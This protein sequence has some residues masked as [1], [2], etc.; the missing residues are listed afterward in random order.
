[1][2]MMTVKDA[3]NLI[4][5]KSGPAISLYLVTDVS[6]RDGASKLRLNLQR[7]YK[8]AEGL[9]GRTYDGTTRERLLSSLKRALSMV[10]LKRAKGGVGIYHSEQF[11]GM[12]QLPNVTADLAVASDSFHIKPVL[13]CTQSRRNYYLL[14]LKRKYAE[15]LLVTADG[16]K[17]VDRIGINAG[18]VG[19][20]SAERGNRQWSSDGLKIRRQKDLKHAMELLNRKL[21]H[22]WRGERIPLVL[23][24]PPYSQEAFRGACS[25]MYMIERGVPVNV[26]ELDMDN[27]VSASLTAMAGYFD[28]LDDHAVVSFRRAHASGLVSTN[29]EAIA[30]A[31]AMG[32]IQSLLVAEDRH[33][34]GHLDRDT[35]HVKVLDSI[36]QAA[37]DDLLDDIAELTLNKGGSVTVLPYMRMPDNHF[38][39]AVLRWSEAPVPMVVARYVPRHPAR[40]QA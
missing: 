6:E 36:P 23:A 11:T 10:G 21:E 14:A 5:V 1:M 25:Y 34:W 20:V 13:R 29:L 12:V 30:K 9:I 8:T 16:P 7:L 17:L 38:I 24:G 32:Q 37:A 26:D 2:K 39:A 4:K 28:F 40:L 31:A 35:G 27:L 18:N 22:H 33:I 3:A 19:S 15:L